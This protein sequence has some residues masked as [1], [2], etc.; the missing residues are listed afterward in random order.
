MEP[1]V[2]NP[3]TSPPAAIEERPADRLAD[4]IVRFLV[5][6]AVVVVLD[7]VTKGLIRGWL[8]VGERWPA[9]W[10]LIQLSHVRNTGA[11][12]G[13]LQGAGS[14]LIVAALAGIGVM[15]F[16]LLTLP[17]HSRWY[18]VALSAV[19]GGAVG[20]L[21]DRVRLG[22]VTDFIDPAHYP[23]F[24]VADSAIVCG[25]IAIAALSF[26]DDRRARNDPPAGPL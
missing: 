8:D 24:N 5:V 23:A 12:F 9:D 10:T 19:L 4:R 3:Q 22:H 18:T 17:A 21:I 11:A 7:Q 14:F 1:T 15:T 26:L 6:A 16:Y 2:A 13:I 20:N 25:I